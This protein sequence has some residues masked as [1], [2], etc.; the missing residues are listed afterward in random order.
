MNVGLQLQLN[1]W[2][3]NLIT[4]EAMECYIDHYNNKPTEQHCDISTECPIH[5]WDEDCIVV[6][7]ISDKHP[8][9]GMVVE[10]CN[11]MDV[12]EGD[13][14]YMYHIGHEIEGFWIVNVDYIIARVNR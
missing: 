14:V 4:D 5:A 3:N 7:P 11:S 10:C 9:K 13:I 1:L 8:Y 2:K 6:K 12:N